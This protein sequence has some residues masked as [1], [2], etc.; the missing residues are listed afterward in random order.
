MSQVCLEKNQTHE[1]S[2]GKSVSAPEPTS[3]A[4]TQVRL[5]EVSLP[6]SPGPCVDVRHVYLATLVI[7]GS[8]ALS[9][10]IA[11]SW[12]LFQFA[13]AASAVTLVWTGWYVANRWLRQSRYQSLLVAVYFAVPCL[14]GIA[15]GL[16]LSWCLLLSFSVPL[17]WVWSRYRDTAQVLTSLSLDL[18]QAKQTQ[19]ESEKRA[20]SQ[21]EE[22]AAREKKLAQTENRVKQ[23]EERMRRIIDAAYDA[24]VVFDTRGKIT[25]F[26]S[27]AVELFGATAEEALGKSIR[28]FLE[29][30]HIINDLSAGRPKDASNVASC[31]VVESI[32]KHS[33]GKTIPVEVSLSMSRFDGRPEFHAFIHDMSSRKSLQSRMMHLEKMESLGK[34]SA[35]LAHEI[36]TPMQFIGDNMSFLESAIHDVSEILKETKELVE[37]PDELFESHR[38]KISELMSSA[39][40]DFLLEQMSPAIRSS[41]DGLQKVTSI[42]AAMKD[43]ANPN[44]GGKSSVNLCQTIHNVVAVSRNS[45]EKVADLSVDCQCEDAYVECLASEIGQVIMGLI[46][47]AADAIEEKIS[48]GI[49]ER[50][51]IQVRLMVKDETATIEV[52]DDGMGIPEAIRGRIFD[53]FFTTRDVGKGTGH[54]LTIVHSVIVDK[55]EGSVQFRTEVGQGTCF[56]VQIPA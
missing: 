9:E 29:Y 25:T 38:Q 47:N 5:G 13:V 20:R 28:S 8:I 36:N 39:D 19:M 24:F 16:P 31:G 22:V 55:H 52:E 4:T 10:A 6:I 23:N 42:T 2:T 51:T 18:Q 46:L 35:G 26:S 21:T 15:W 48:K 27:R 34:L 43:F 33:S 41:M 49:A 40:I 37:D 44:V 53:P 32:A 7:L 12:S 30:D 11:V 17:A 3:S 45:W 14:N 50:G 54:G 1:P 56:I